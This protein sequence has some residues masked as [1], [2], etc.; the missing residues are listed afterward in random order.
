M[1][2]LSELGRR[3]GMLFGGTR[4]DR[5]LRDEM[6]LHLELRQQEHMGRGLPADEAHAAAQEADGSS[7]LHL[8]RRA[9][10]ARGRSPALRHGT[11]AW[12]DSPAGVLA[13]ERAA[14]GD[15]RVVVVNMTGKTVTFPGK[16]TLVLSSAPAE[17]GW[18]GTVGPWAA[19]W[20]APA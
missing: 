12:L 3:L 2:W 13:W 17:S 7:F 20:L 10:T 9:L 16:F 5:D 18:S 15:R 14:P 6:R 11:F 8:Y 4:F 19:V 1:E